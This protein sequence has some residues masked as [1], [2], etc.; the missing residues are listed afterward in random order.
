MLTARITNGTFLLKPDSE[1]RSHMNGIIGRAQRKTDTPIYAV[2]YQVNHHHFL[3]GARDAQQLA[4]FMYRVQQQT[5]VEI[6]IRHGWKGPKWETPYKPS[7]IGRDPADTSKRF[8][9]VLA[10]GCAAG[11]VS[12]P[13][14]WPGVT[15]ARALWEGKFELEGEWVDHTAYCRAKRTK[16]GRHLTKKDFTKKE[17]VV[18]SKLPGLDHLSDEDYCEWVREMIRGIERETRARHKREG[19]KPAGQW[20]LFRLSPFGTPRKMALGPCPLVIAS[21]ED[22]QQRLLAAFDWVWRAHRLARDRQREGELDVK[23][24]EGTFPSPRP[25][26]TVQALRAGP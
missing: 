11:L 15:V 26:E 22:E 24:P 1:Q 3:V 17:T 21:N 25:F 19:T 7:F 2:D 23:F 20:K 16:A 8:R 4:D 5:S 9:Y 18:I 6:R 13:L 10:Q 14:K 12:S